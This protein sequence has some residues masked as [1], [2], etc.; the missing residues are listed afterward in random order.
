MPV[1]VA[2]EN[3]MLDATKGV[4]CDEI[5]QELQMYAKDVN[6][7]RFVKNLQHGKLSIRQ[8]TSCQ[9]FEQYT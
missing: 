1:V 7:S 5:P 3:L 4:V 2:I 6:M 9:C 8:V